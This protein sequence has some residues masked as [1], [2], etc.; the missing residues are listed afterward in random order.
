MTDAVGAH[1][2]GTSFASRVRP[3]EA[4]A[5]ETAAPVG[6]AIGRP[7]EEPP[8]SHYVYLLRCADGSL[9]CGYSTDPV[10]RAKVHNSGKGAKYTR[11]R[12]PVELVYAEPCPSKEAALSREW[13][14]KRLTRRQKEDLIR[15]SAP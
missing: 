6:A 11:S 10:R 4:A 8:R 1:P 7:P 9:Y 12:L 14:I 3:P 13:H 2:I 15:R 5:S